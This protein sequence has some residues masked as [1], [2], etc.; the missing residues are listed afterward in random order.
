M[1]LEKKSLSDEVF[2]TIRELI[3]TGEIPSG[4]K[5][6][7]PSLAKKLS[8]SR[9]PIRDAI[10]KLQTCGLVERQLNIGARV[11]QLTNEKLIEVYHIREQLE[12]L[13]ARFAAENI[14]D[15]SLKYLQLL[16]SK[17][18]KQLNEKQEYYQKQGDLDFHYLIVKASNNSHLIRLFND[19]LYYLIRVYRFQFAM[20]G[21][22]V[23]S[24]YQEHG[25]IVDAIAHKDG[26]MAELLMRQHIRLSRMNI[27]KQLNWKGDDESR[28]AI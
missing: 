23:N 19:S 27:E 5:I 24:A 12:G 8:V 25:A 10:A 1:Q 4:S 20:R 6:S 18:K 16:L 14:D 17:Q 2:Q 11:T 7:E 21:R 28:Q 15:E 13:A 9:V 22:R 26:E 3:E